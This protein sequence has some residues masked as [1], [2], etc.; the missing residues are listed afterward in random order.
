MF[1]N[2]FPPPFF[3]HFAIAM[4]VVPSCAFLLC[5]SSV[6]RFLVVYFHSIR[7]IVSAQ[8]V[9]IN[10]TGEYFI[11]RTNNRVSY[12]QKPWTVK[13]P[14]SAT[15][16]KYQKKAKHLDTGNEKEATTARTPCAAR[17]TKADSSE[18]PKKKHERR[19]YVAIASI[20]LFGTVN[21]FIILDSFFAFDCIRFGY[22]YF[23][24]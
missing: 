6:A 12:K 9:E 22:S 2:A 11:K 14:T 8:S 5:H 24:V 3:S 4:Y 18:N 20:C 23:L 7:G 10:T 21:F 13:Y 16:A 1:L 15:K 19:K 17:E